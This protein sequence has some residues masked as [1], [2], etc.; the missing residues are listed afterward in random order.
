MTTPEDKI[1]NVIG[2]LLNGA[3]E[4]DALDAHLSSLMKNEKTALL[5]DNNNIYHATRSMGFQID[6]VKLRMILES[7]CN[8]RSA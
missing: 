8:L 4:R 3:Q 7:R 6:Y 5:V 1:T 2:D